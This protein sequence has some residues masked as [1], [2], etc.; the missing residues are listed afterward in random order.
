MALSSLTTDI[1]CLLGIKSKVHSVYRSHAKPSL[2]LGLEPRGSLD[3]EELV[4]PTGT[5]CIDAS[6][7]TLAG[8]K[9][10]HID[11]YTASSTR[12]VVTHSSAA[13]LWFGYT[14]NLDG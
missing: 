4:F 5:A 7:S 9:H 3:S 2:F 14:H 8:S 1:I 13:L 11:V 10:V 12:H 6:A